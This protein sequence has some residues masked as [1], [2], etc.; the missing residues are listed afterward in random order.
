[1]EKTEN[2]KI[3]DVSKIVSELW[4]R[5][6]LFYKVWAITFVLSC[7]WI[8]PQPRYYTCEVKLAPEMSGEDVGGGLSSI[9]QSFGFNI[10]GV[11]GQDAI[12]P[13]L[14]P[15]LFESPEFIVG[16][17]GIQV[18]TKDGEIST[19][20]FTYMKQ[21]QKP[22]WLLVPYIKAR[23][24]VNGLF[25]ERDTT[26]RGTGNGDI[27]P[28]MMNRDDYKL[29]TTIMGNIKCSVDKKTNVITINVTDQDP[30]ICATMADSV[31]DHLQAFIIRY[32]T[33]K[34]QEDVTYYQQMRDSA[35]QDYDKAIEAYSRFCDT[36]KGIIL[37]SF[38]SERDK[39]EGELSL[40][41]NSLAVMETQLQSTKVKLQEKTPA[42]T[43]LQSAVVPI[44]PAGPK[45]MLFIIG[46]MLVAS[47]L[48]S[49]YVVKDML[50]AG[51]DKKEA[52]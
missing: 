39:L 33:S 2:Q 48:L 28:F 26:P 41:Q 43:T 35:E 13:E 27:N 37:Q 36:H 12:Y 17:Y 6:K 47:L 21:H 46:M 5:K 38:Q 3:I 34:A 20:Y 16:L 42:F 14:Y 23:N 50:F 49:L 31:K 19:N 45:R 8:L 32:R 25:E 1:M 18:K 9:A 40:R 15:D 10:G 22:N 52:Q 24:W 7:I 11:G 44:K 4:R 51:S 30:L 29:M